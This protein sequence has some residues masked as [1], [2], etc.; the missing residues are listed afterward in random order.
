MNKFWKFEF[1]DQIELEMSGE[2]GI[3][4]G[5]SEYYQGMADQ[6][7]I[8]YVNGNGC[9]TEAWVLESMIQHID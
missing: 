9:Q 4:V 5:R 3:V 6:Y 1:G 2:R 7:L 8:R